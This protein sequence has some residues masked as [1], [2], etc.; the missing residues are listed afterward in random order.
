MIQFVTSKQNA[1]ADALSHLPVTNADTGKEDTFHI[2]Q[3]LL[4]S[5]PGTNTR[6]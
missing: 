2:G 4:E 5:S 6:D 1:V 3:K